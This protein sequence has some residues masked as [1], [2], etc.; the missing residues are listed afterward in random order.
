MNGKIMGHELINMPNDEI[1]N[2]RMN[3]LEDNM[4]RC[5]AQH[6]WKIMAA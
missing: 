5:F 6:D 4:D 3:Q 1:V 2:A